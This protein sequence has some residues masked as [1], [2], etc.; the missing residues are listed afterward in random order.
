M[1]RRKPKPKRRRRDPDIEIMTQEQWQLWVL[2]ECA[3]WL[4]A[5]HSIVP[6]GADYLRRCWLALVK[7]QSSCQ[8][9]GCRAA[10]GV[11]S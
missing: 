7:H 8:C 9:H 3:T 2:R 10:R 5:G 6:E 11:T 1:T 4:E